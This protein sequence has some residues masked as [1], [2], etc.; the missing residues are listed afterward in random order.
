MFDLTGSTASRTFVSRSP[1]LVLTWLLL[2]STTAIGAMPMRFAHLNLESGLSQNT[3]LSLLQDSRGFMWIGTENGLNRYDG[4]VVERYFHDPKDPNSIS[5]D[6]IWDIAEDNASNL[7]I[8]TSNGGLQRWIRET[9]SFESFELASGSGAAIRGVSSVERHSDGTIWVGT[10]ENGY[11]I[12][13][14]E[15]LRV[16]QHSNSRVSEASA[17]QIKEI[18]FTRDGLALIGTRQNVEIRLTNGGATQFLFES[19][20]TGKNP[21]Y[22]NFSFAETAEG[23]IFVASPTLGLRQ[24]RRSESGG[25]FQVTRD[26]SSQL[27]GATSQ[28]VFVDSKNR[29][30][31]GTQSGLLRYNRRTDSFVRYAHDPST[32][33]SLGSNYV[34]SIY[35]DRNGLIWVGTRGA[36][37]S[38]WNPRT[39]ALGETTHP[40][41]DG[42]VINAFAP[43]AD[44]QT[45]IGTIGSGLVLH[46][47]TTDAFTR[48][49][50]R[51]GFEDLADQR[52][53]SLLTTTDGDLWIGTLAGGLHRYNFD[54]QTLRNFRR[55]PDDDSLG[56]DGIMS[57]Y[58]SADGTVWAGTFGGGMAQIDPASNAVKRY[59]FRADDAKA[60]PSSRVTAFA[61]AGAAGQGLWV[62]TLH[63]GLAW[64]DRESGEFTHVEAAG[65]GLTDG[66]IYALHRQADGTVW[67]GTAGGGLI[68]LTGSA[69]R[70]TVEAWST[71]QGFSSNVI[72]GIQP[73]TDGHLWLS[74]NDGLMRFDPTTGATEHFQRT[75]GLHGDEFNFNA[76]ARR[77]DGKLYFGGSGGF[78]AF[79]PADVQ[80]NL[81]APQLALT[82]FELFNE[83]AELPTPYPQL[84]S[85]ALTHRDDVI[86]F[87]FAA[88]DFSAPDA[89]QYSY[90]L[91]GFDKNWS[92]P[93]HR[94][95]AT[96]TNL[97]SGDYTFR[98]RAS[99]GEGAWTGEDEELRI[100]V[101]VAPPPWGTW[102]AYLIY[103]VVVTSLAYG[104]LRYR[105][106]RAEAAA[107][108]RQLTFYDRPTGLPN[109]K[110]F[111]Q[112]L[113]QALDTHTDG[114]LAILCVQAYDRRD[115]FEALGYE[116][117]DVVMVELA[118]R[119]SRV[120]TTQQAD[121]RTIGLARISDNAF[122]VMLNAD[123]AVAL[124]HLIGQKLLDTATVPISTRQSELALNATVGIAARGAPGQTANQLITHAVLAAS[125]AREANL[126]M[127]AYVDS[128]SDSARDRLALEHDLAA[129]IDNNALAL[130]VQ[131][132]YASD[133]TLVGGEALLRW[134]HPTRGWVPPSDFVPIAEQ[135]RLSPRLN[136]WV[137]AQACDIVGEWAADGAQPVP[138]AVNVS[139][140]EYLTGR[141][142]D[143][144]DEHVAR[145]GLSAPQIE[146]EV[147][148]SVLM[149][150]LDAVQDCLAQLRDRGHT[151]A[152]DDFGTGYSS[153]KYL[154][155]LPIDRVKIDRGFVNE[156]ESNADQ[157]EICRAIIGLATSLGMST[158]AEGVET[159]AQRDL[160]ADM[161]CASF[162]GYYHSPAIPAREFR[163]L[164]R[165]AA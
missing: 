61:D 81:Q 41:L 18:S 145:A 47:E 48:F 107:H 99:N 72:Y 90:M 60:V 66:T 98:V 144:L 88:L 143:L 130:Y 30:W 10:L 157:L 54:D 92:L 129:A 153:L 103:A 91:D 87:G 40:I 100:D 37:T 149:R 123:D 114:E 116:L 31:V 62:G 12:I 156:L 159:L 46:D 23:D 147:T 33:S 27:R 111:E 15:S 86:T 148:E 83:P 139:S 71:P 34:L 106:R 84:E 73:G 24:L 162:Q 3:V 146:V 140:Q 150:D 9:G 82:S 69:A 142:V 70:P 131:P 56:A 57:L 117:I 74:S 136:Q 20:E 165:P 28:T 25:Q 16:V 160:L 52:I 32:P 43:M 158:V 93:A 122:G 22:V 44:G 112:R 42:A 89:N 1:L 113:A 110:L 161:G 97:D 124:A 49:S 141:I 118:T 163:K 7:W 5:S 94:Q 17:K 35:E 109:R 38:R 36:G 8:G 128:M 152:L 126:Q 58:E 101:S 108:L 134:H 105:I 59:A 45:W 102:W 127:T 64:L 138:L 2:T 115:S 85:I 95:R 21:E 4:T 68:R 151:V 26:F 11:F 79:K 77:A 125:E 65:T 63:G 78:N 67:A 51:D 154:Q 96:Y 39:W 120:L 135:S 13:D 29:I 19:A 104:F 76:H 80:R 53:M 155:R 121:G 55:G 119:V 14:P 133:D 50:L 137:I 164:L 75:H 6:Y 132:K